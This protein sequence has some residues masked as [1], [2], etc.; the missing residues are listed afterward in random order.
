MTSCSE[1]IYHNM[2]NKKTIMN[3]LDNYFKAVD[4]DKVDEYHKIRGRD[5]NKK[6]F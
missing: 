1:R 5:K 6:I 3:R 2:E 4:D